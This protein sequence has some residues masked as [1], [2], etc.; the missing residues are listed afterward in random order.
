MNNVNESLGIDSLEI[1]IDANGMNQYKESLKAELLQTSKDKIKNYA[2]L[3]AAL[4]K[5]WQGASYQVFKTQFT[6]TTEKICEDLDKE[7]Q[8]LEARLTDLQSAYFNID[9]QIMGN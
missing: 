6:T 4:D 2:D 1:G 7:Y 9:N 8:D 5:G 3:E